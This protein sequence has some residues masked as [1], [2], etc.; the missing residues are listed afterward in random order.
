MIPAPVCY[1]FFLSETMF[2]TKKQP[3]IQF[4]ILIPNLGPCFYVDMCPCTTI[5]NMSCTGCTGVVGFLVAPAF[6]YFR[7]MAWTAV[8]PDSSLCGCAL[9]SSRI[10]ILVLVPVCILDGQ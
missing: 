8:N 7:H 2:T 6:C 3:S 1:I 5:I 4:C 9:G 10:I